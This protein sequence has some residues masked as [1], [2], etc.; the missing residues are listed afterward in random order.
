MTPNLNASTIQDYKGNPIAEPFRLRTLAILEQDRQ[1]R[2][3]EYRSGNKDG[4]IRV[5]HRSKPSPNPPFLDARLQ[6][7]LCQ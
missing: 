4:I 3:I 2:L 6:E 5:T 1:A 7:P